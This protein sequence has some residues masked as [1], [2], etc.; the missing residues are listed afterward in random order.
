MKPKWSPHAK[1]LLADIL[2][3]IGFERS[4]QDAARWSLCIQEESDQLETF[5]FLGTTIPNECFMTMP[6]NADR[7]RQ[8]F[9]G[10]Y[11]IVYEPV[12]DEIHI[13]S[14]R[15]T[16]MLVTEGDTYWS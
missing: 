9:C 2:H 7:L 6:D 13:L 16:R 5:P 15:H 10:P 11:R 14:I 1:S 4:P 3:V 12:E 8:I